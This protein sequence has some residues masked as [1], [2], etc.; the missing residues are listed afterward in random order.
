MTDFFTD[1]EHEL[2]AAAERPP[3]RLA[4]WPATAGRGLAGGVAVVAF[5]AA[6]VPALL[7][8]GTG[9]GQQTESESRSAPA[10]GMVIHK[11]E[12]LPPREEESTV[13][14]TGRTKISGPW[15]IESYRGAGLKDPKTGEV[16]EPAGLRCLRMVLS[17]PPPGSFVMS[18]GCG[19]FPKTPGFSRLQVTVPN[20]RVRGEA[21]DPKA[22]EIL[23]YGRV[24]E[25]ALGVDLSAPGRE[26]TRYE[27][28]DGPPGDR[29][30]YYLIAVPSDLKD[31]RVDLITPEGVAGRIRLLPP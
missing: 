23:V 29:S 24:P 26:P 12:G 28:L 4:G 21:I 6:L 19:E 7:I 20:R 2:R 15:Q 10:V 3:R 18:G 11:G 31:A 13:V 8:F 14:A 22:T 25:Q 9:D 5:A 16:Y 30:D 1:L 27:T 17:D